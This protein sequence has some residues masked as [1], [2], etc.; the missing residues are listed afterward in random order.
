MLHLLLFIDANLTLQVIEFLRSLEI[1]NYHFDKF[2]KYAIIDGKYIEM[3]NYPKKFMEEN[4]TTRFFANA[5]IPSV[6]FGKQI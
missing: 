4:L 6:L 5:L 2:N 1:A 3:S